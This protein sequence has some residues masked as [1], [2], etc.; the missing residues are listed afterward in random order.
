MATNAFEALCLL[1]S[2]EQWCWRM[3]CTTC[4]HMYF[5][6]ALRELATGKSPESSPWL[7]TSKNEALRRGAPLKALGPAPPL[8]AWPLAEQRGLSTVLAQANL[9]HIASSCLYPDWLG[10]LG[11]ALR[12]TEDVE[13]E[14][15]QLTQAWTPQLRKLVTPD[16]AAARALDALMRDQR[17]VLRWSDMEGVEA[18]ATACSSTS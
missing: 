1:A 2:Q 10:Y 14:A 18:A 3:Y 12:Y 11:L 15:R 7:V 17:R 5:R 16:S 4:G 6:Y 8:S 13:Q 9:A